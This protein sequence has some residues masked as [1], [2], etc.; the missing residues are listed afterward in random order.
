MNQ[1]EERKVS[2]VEGLT[3]KEAK[4]FFEK[5]KQTDRVSRDWLLKAMIDYQ[6]SEQKEGSQNG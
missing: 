5:F 2:T 3:V 1:T 4:D 6:N